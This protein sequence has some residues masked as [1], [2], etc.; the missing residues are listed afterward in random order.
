MSLIRRLGLWVHRGGLLGAVGLLVAGEVFAQ[1]DAQGPAPAAAASPASASSPGDSP[2]AVAPAALAVDRAQ[3][4]VWQLNIEAPSPLDRLL[5]TYLDLARFQQEAEQDSTLGIR[6]S[7]LRRLVASAPEQA[8]GLIEAE[9]YF[10]AVISTRVKDEQRDQPVVVTIKVEPGP[11]TVV[12]KVQ[13]VYEGDLDTRLAAS[14]PLA[15]ALVDKVE[16]DWALPEGQVFRQAEWS[17]AKNVALARLRADGFPASTWSGTSVTVDAQTQTAK[18][19]LVADTGPAFA[20]GDI[21]VEGLVRQPSSAVT[22]L[23]PFHKGSAYSE[24][25]LLDW[26]ERIQKLNLFDNVFVTTELDPTQASTTP[27]LVQVHELPMQT[28]TS[29]I[30]VSSDTGPRVSGEYLHRNP[31]GLDWQ[32]KA[33]AQLGRK[34]SSGQLDLTS[35]PWPGRRRGLISAQA[36][37]LVENDDSVSTSQQV[38]AGQLREGERLERTDYIEFQRAE[39]RSAEDTIVSNAKAVSATSQWIFRDVDS[40]TL[41]TNGSTSMA[42]LTA[43]R[44]YSALDQAGYFGRA[45]ARVTLYKPLWANWKGIAR[46]ELGQVFARDNVSVPDTQLFRAGGDDSVRGYPYRSLGVVSEGVV[47]GGRSIATASLEAAHPLLKR[48]PNLLGAV[49]VDAGDAAERFGKLRPHVGYGVGLRWL[50]PVGPLRLDVAFGDGLDRWRLH[51]S[52]GVSL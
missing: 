15:Q 45:Y 49:F 35:H 38:R 14:D 12:S 47:L 17:S 50:S 48:M 8:R 33:K 16:G 39:V 2:D 25:Q 40:Q 10:N 41:P 20:F 18:L 7:E 22:N 34:A 19:F 1:V 21:R 23:A 3:P 30:G 31:F 13:F 32:A 9:G 5:R 51:F 28:A 11:Q 42:Q 43:G 4:V 44:T 36:S 6:R 29:G 46:G 24:K 37:Y 27:V 52:V 26:Q